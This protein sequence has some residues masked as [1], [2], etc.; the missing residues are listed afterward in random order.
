MSRMG[1]FA[2]GASV[3]SEPQSLQN[4]S[5]TFNAKVPGKFTANGLN[6]PIMDSPDGMSARD[7]K[8]QTP[9]GELPSEN[10]SSDSTYTA[11]NPDQFGTALGI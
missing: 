4:S 7:A 8:R 6:Q 3:V 11:I 9:N 5:M 1:N 2:S 10:G